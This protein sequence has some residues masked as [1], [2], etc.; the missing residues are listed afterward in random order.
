VEAPGAKISFEVGVAEWRA[1]LR[2][3]MVVGGLSVRWWRRERM[4]R[5]GGIKMCEDSF[6]MFGIAF[7]FQISSMFVIKKI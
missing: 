6:E 1:I 3:R 4:G 2:G 7:A 5:R